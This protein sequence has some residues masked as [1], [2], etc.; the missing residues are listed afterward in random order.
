LSESER[1]LGFST[2]V[3]HARDEKIRVLQDM[4]KEKMT[5]RLEQSMEELGCGR[6]SRETKNQ[7]EKEEGLTGKEE[8]FSVHKRK[9]NTKGSNHGVI[10]HSDTTDRLG[11]EECATPHLSIALT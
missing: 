10:P 2:G 11:M 7:P 4:Q 9:G 1:R 6:T 8:A 5:H 3:S